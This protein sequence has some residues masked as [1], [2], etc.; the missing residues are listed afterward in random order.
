MRKGKFTTKLKSDDNTFKE[1][2]RR[3]PNNPI[4]TAKDWSYP[5]HSVF[6]P[7][8]TTFEG[9]VLGT[10]YKQKSYLSPLIKIA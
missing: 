6:N 2:F 5:V 10:F 8:A 7:G 4:L 3:H 1:L 9:K